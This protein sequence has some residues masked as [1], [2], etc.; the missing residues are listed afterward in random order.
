MGEVDAADFQSDGET[1][2]IHHGDAYQYIRHEGAVHDGLNVSYA[3]KA[4][5]KGYLSGVAKL[6]ED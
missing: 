5:G 4:V 2:Q 1:E 3:A 6:I